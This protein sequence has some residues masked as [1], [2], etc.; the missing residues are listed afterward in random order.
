MT[1]APG[2]FSMDPAELGRLRWRCRRGMRE[3]DV[4]MMRFLEQD[5]PRATPAERAAFSELLDR[6]DPEI[7]ALLLGRLQPEDE[8]LVRVLESLRRPA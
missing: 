6:Q 4:L 7:Y 3:L 8:A 1:S 5:F 2:V